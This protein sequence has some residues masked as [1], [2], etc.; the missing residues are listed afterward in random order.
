MDKTTFRRPPKW[1]APKLSSR[2]VRVWQ[3]L[4]RII[5][6]KLMR[7]PEVEYLGLNRVT[8]AI[9]RNEGVLIT[10]N[11]SSHADATVMYRAAE[12]VG[13]PFYFMSAWQVLG[14]V[15][16][17][18]SKI[19]QHHGCFSVDREGTDMQAFR[20]AVTILK[21]KTNPLVIFPEGEVYHINERVTPFREGP[22]AIAITASKKA[23]RPVVCIPCGIRY[24]YIDDPM[25]E[26]LLLMEQLES[27]IYWRPRPDLELPQRIYRLAQAVLALKEIEYLGQA[28]NMELSGR[29]T[30]LSVEVLEQW[31]KTYQVESGDHT[32]PERV[33]T[34][35][36]VAIARMEDTVETG[37]TYQEAQQ[38]LDDLYFVVQ[39]F[40]YPGDY[41]AENPKIE[42][43]AETLDK[44][45]EDMLGVRT[46]SIR[47]KRRAV[48][49]FGEP[50]GVDRNRKPKLTPSALTDQLEAGVQSLLDNV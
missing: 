3:P 4:R 9:S 16:W 24:S 49:S 29:V 45:E 7:L 22:A 11:H 27:H 8:E 26:M 6:Y 34:L 48:I 33:K 38:A 47:G 18:R 31:E 43:M 32:I 10:P 19:L 46:A 2:W 36:Q 14:T 37:A 39:L 25:P 13:M 35:R 15:T 1:W 23:D 41:V 12:Q 5:Q 28:Q 30:S 40:S 42:R 20:Q 44:F 21:E 17:L 50:I